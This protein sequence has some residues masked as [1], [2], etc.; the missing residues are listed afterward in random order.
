[1][2][3]A[4]IIIFV[5]VLILGLHIMPIIGKSEARADIVNLLKMGPEDWEPSGWDVNG[6]AVKQVIDVLGWNA[7]ATV[8]NFGIG[9]GSV[10][11][12]TDDLSNQ[13]VD[14]TSKDFMGAE[15][16][17]QPWNLG[18]INKSDSQANDTETNESSTAGNSTLNRSNS[19]VH[20]AEDNHSN[21]RYGHDH[22]NLTAEDNLT[23]GSNLTR[24]NNS[25]SGSNSTST[26][27]GNLTEAGN[28]TAMNNPSDITDFTYP[29]YHPI[30]FGH[31]FRDLVYEHPL[32]VTGT[33]Y[34]RLMG[35]ETPGGALNMAMKSSGYGY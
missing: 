21:D 11:M 6:S 5:P 26:Y 13:D 23:P 18:R 29:Y 28:S 31:P 27:S 24:I 20:K 35:L 30:S 16:S 2:K 10:R 19:G 25:T 3:V 8:G 33:T 7:T 9:D 34:C 22:L 4:V 12:F 1:M 15:I 32:T 17:T 14:F